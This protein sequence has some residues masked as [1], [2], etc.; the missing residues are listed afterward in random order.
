[1]PV[2]VTEVLTRAAKALSDVDEVRWTA[3]TKLDYFNDGLLEISVQKPTAFSRTVELALAAGTL[4]TVPDAYS[5]LLRMV[6]NVTSAA[7]ATARTGG[8]S[9]TPTD[10]EILDAQFIDWHDPA[11]IPFSKDVQHVIA[12]EFEP[13]QFYVFPGNTGSG[14]VEAI[15]AQ[16]PDP[17]T[18]TITASTQAPLDRSYAN[19]LADYVCYRCYAEDAILSGTTQR[20]QAH[21]SL[22]QSALGIRQDIEGAQNVNTTNQG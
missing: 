9:I 13:R 11:T 19:A 6:R 1:M 5:G 3:D 22:F 18:G 16:I 8:R 10:R 2:N 12:D 21:Y 14:I 15:M 17:I 20:A 4:Q 7:G